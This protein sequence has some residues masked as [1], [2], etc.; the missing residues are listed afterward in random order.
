MKKLGFIYS[1]KLFINYKRKGNKKLH[2][3]ICGHL[4]Q[5]DGS[6]KKLKI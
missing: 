3:P 6:I 5:I 4:S 2:V 1:H